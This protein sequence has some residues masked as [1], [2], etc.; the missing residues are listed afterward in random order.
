MGCL[1]L[2]FPRNTLRQ[3]VYLGGAGTL[4]GKR[5]IHMGKRRQSMKCVL[6]SSYFS[7]QLKINPTGKP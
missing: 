2:G 5:R 3:I 4:V 7:G 6:Q 1:I